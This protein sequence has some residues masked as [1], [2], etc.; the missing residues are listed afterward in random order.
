MAITQHRMLQLI[1]TCDSF[2]Q[3]LLRAQSFLQSELNRALAGQDAP[4]KILQELALFVSPM[5]MTPNYVESITLLAIEKE[6]FRTSHSRNVAS[7]KWQK[8][9]REDAAAAAGRTIQPR[10][11]VTLQIKQEMPGLVNQQSETIV[12][13]SDVQASR[14]PA[15]LPP[16]R[17]ADEL[18]SESMDD[19]SEVSLFPSAGGAGAREDE[20]NID[21]INLDFDPSRVSPDLMVEVEQALRESRVRR[22]EP[23]VQPSPQPQ[24]EDKS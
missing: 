11:H 8:K 20:I 12:V 13:Q 19:A 24:K 18:E 2:H 5:T 7:A 23:A 22:G 17:F 16:G 6:H 21:G 9:K 4:L 10:K 1:A 15:A 3:G 14:A